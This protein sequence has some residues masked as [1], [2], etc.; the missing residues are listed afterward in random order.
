MDHLRELL[1]GLFVEF[2]AS[3]YEVRSFTYDRPARDAHVDQ[4]EAELGFQVPAALRTLFTQVSSHVELRWHAPPELEYARPFH[5]NFGGAL[6][7]CLKGLVELHRSKERWV[8]QVFPDSKDAYDRVWHQKL[9]FQA[10]PNSDFLALDLAPDTL[11]QVVY[12]SHDDGE[13]HG[14]VLANNLLDL[15]RSWVPLA[16]TGGES[17]QWLP[18]YD[19]QSQ[20]LDP[21]SDRA[22][23]WRQLLGLS[24]DLQARLES[25]AVARPA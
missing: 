5:E 18:F 22:R 1:V 9:A 23:E 25:F 21:L 16:C 14:Y 17:W 3:G 8:E 10:L 4:V 12:L 13:G 6:H 15:I 24:S 2:E 20:R 19:A 11:G 7:W